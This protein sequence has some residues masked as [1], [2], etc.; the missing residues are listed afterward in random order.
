MEG[1]AQHLAGL[2][3]V[4]GASAAAEAK[5]LMDSGSSI[6]AVWEELVQTL[7]G[8]T[9]MTQS[10]LT[11]TFVGHAHEVTSLGQECDIETQSCPFHLTIEAP[12]IPVRFTVPFIVLPGGGDVDIIGQ[13][14]LKEKLGIDVMAQLKASVLKAQRRQDG[15][16]MELT[17]RP[18]GEPNDGAVLRAAMAVTAFVPG[19]DPPG[20]VDDDVTLTLSQLPMIFRILMWKCRIVWAC[21]RRLSITL[22]TMAPRR[23]VPR[24]CAIS[25]FVRTLTSYFRRF[26]G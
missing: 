9:G 13:R 11:Q 23:N 18:V 3:A 1:L 25:F 20:N 8:Q 2:L 7:G 6:T 15:A 12:W 19:G 5:V 16:G 10:A 14:T 26:V 22:L 24:C 17:A 21:W 4:P